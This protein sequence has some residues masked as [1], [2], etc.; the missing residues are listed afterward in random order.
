LAMAGALDSLCERQHVLENIEIILRFTSALSKGKNADQIGMFAEEDNEELYTLALQE[1]PPADQKTRLQWERELLGIYVSDHPI[2]TYLPYL[3]ADRTAVLALNP[4][5]N[6][7][8]VRVAGIVMSVRKILTK[9]NQNMAFVGLE[10]DTGLVEVIVFP[11]T[12]AEKEKMIVVG[13]ALAVEGKVSRK[14]RRERRVM[15]TM[16]NNPEDQVEHQEEPVQEIKIL[17]ENCQKVSTEKV[18]SKKNPT[19]VKLSIP[20]DGDRTLLQR[21]KDCLEKY[22]GK[23]PVTLL[24]P[25]LEGEQEMKISHKVE[26]SEILYSQLAYLIGSDHVA[27]E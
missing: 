3:P 27:I 16:D 20:E 1:C 15:T 5:E 26:A 14:D 2:S 11:R 22:P 4:I 9:S 13:E 12:W 24:L 21:I 6:N 23:I 19:H 25:T 17:M 8:I 7:T 18:M 10:D